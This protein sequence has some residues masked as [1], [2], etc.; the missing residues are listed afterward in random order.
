MLSPSNTQ[1]EEL[2]YPIGRFQLPMERSKMLAVGYIQ[3]I[4][5]LPGQMAEAVHGL[6]QEQLDTPYRPE[7]WTVRQVVHHTADSHMNS[8]IRFKLTLT[9]EYPTIRP[10]HEDRWAELEDG[11]RAPVDISLQL[12]ASLHRRWTMMLRNMSEEDFDRQFFHPASKSSMNL[13]EAAAMYAW[14]GRHHLAQITELK[15]RKA[16]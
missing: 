5:Q 1:I 11:K 15:K 3:A 14:H 6:S 7:G 8:I 16:W 4:E 2:R 13:Y 9:E 12:L 10:Y